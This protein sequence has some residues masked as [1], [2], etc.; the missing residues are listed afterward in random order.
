M[1]PPPECKRFHSG[2]PAVARPARLLAL[3]PDLVD[4]A[5][6]DESPDLVVQVGDLSDGEG[7]LRLAAGRCGQQQERDKA[8]W[9]ESLHGN[10]A[11]SVVNG[12][13]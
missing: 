12:G 7:G 13:C 11:G 8:G 4:L 6:A 9:K 10:A 3:D 1:S 5:I 2:W